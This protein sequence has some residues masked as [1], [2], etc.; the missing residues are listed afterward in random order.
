MATSDTTIRSHA[1]P[2]HQRAGDDTEAT[3]EF[4]AIYQAGFEAGFTMGREAGLKEAGQAAVGQVTAAKKKVRISTRRRV[5]SEHFLLG[6]PC[7]TC[8]AYHGSDEK[9]CPLCKTP[10]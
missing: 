8:G 6:L 1:I 5:A 10:Q 9:R 7:R 4:T 2:L 3:K